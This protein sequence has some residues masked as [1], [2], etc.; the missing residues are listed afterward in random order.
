MAISR[1]SCVASFL[2]DRRVQWKRT[3][4]FGESSVLK[5]GVVCLTPWPSLTKENTQWNLVAPNAKKHWQCLRESRLSAI[6]ISILSVALRAET[7]GYARMP[8]TENRMRWPKACSF[9]ARHLWVDELI[10]MSKK[11]WSALKT[12]RWESWTKRD[13]LA[14]GAKNKS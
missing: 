14:Q 3:Q 5:V 12:A 10:Y 8:Q 4:Q 6:R 7:N 2:L 13:F 1:H 9:S 11:K